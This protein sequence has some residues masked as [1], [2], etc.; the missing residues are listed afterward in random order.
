MV[1]SLRLGLDRLQ[2]MLRSFGPREWSPWPN[3]AF[4]RALC[5]AGR[6][7]PLLMLRFAAQRRTAPL[8]ADVRLH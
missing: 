1:R 2:M 3:Q 6:E 4:E 8:N 5:T 7:A